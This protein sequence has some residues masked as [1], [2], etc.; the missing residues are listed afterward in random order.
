[1]QI[2]PEVLVTAEKWSR[3]WRIAN[4]IFWLALYAAVVVYTDS[5]GVWWV[6]FLEACVPVCF[7]FYLDLVL[8]PG[9]TSQR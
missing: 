3:V 9:G 2:N 8:R 5:W 6:M 1:M 7:A 4:L